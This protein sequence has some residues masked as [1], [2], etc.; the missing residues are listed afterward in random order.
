MDDIFGGSGSGGTQSPPTS[1]SLAR[2]NVDLHASG[3]FRPGEPV[4]INMSVRA[5]L[6]TTDATVDLVLP[7]LAEAELRGGWDQFQPVRGQPIRPLASKRQALSRGAV[8]QH[9]ATVTFPRPG[10]YSVW[11]SVTSTDSVVQNGQPVQNAEHQVLYLLIS[12][13]GGR[14]MQHF[15]PTV[16]PAGSVPG[17]GPF[18]ARGARAAARDGKQRLANQTGS[19]WVLVDYWNPDASNYTPVRNATYRVQAWS[20]LGSLQQTLNGQTDANGYITIPCSAGYRFVVNVW[21]QNGWT[22]VGSTTSNFNSGELIT[23]ATYYADTDCGYTNYPGAT[24][25]VAHVFNNMNT[26][27]DNAYTFFGY[28]RPTGVPVLLVY[29]TS[30]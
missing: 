10:L 24:A 30:L 20:S 18:R 26:T 21:A 4:Q 8:T 29:D 27:A 25:D 13:T 7:E 5:V 22:T 17:L 9:Q 12:E 6:P 1:A 2:F 23:Q 11:A 19:I 14:V 28:Y 15:D 3:S 16:V